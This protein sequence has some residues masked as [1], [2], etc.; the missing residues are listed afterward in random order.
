VFLPR[1]LAAIVVIA[2]FAVPSPA[3]AHEGHV[4]HAP[5]VEKA[6]PAS[7][8]TQ[9]H[10]QAAVVQ[11]AVV[12]AVASAAT[13]SAARA[14]DSGATGNAADCAGHCCGGAA[15]MTCCGAALA[16][17]PFCVPLLR[18]SVRL[19]APRVLPSS[20]LPPEA[21]PKPPKSFA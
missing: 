10:H 13:L 3:S 16:P 18:A 14:A 15:G 9:S 12:Q 8:Q 20:G 6:V 5:G 4:H 11:A 21:L 2:A 7:A 19:V 1:I 17:D